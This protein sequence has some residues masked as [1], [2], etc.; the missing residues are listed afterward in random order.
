[1]RPREGYFVRVYRGGYVAL[2]VEL[3]QELGKP[4]YLGW[5]VQ[6]NKL[7]LWLACP[8]SENRV[9]VGHGK[10]NN[11]IRQFHSRR[12]THIK[13]GRY[14]AESTGDWATIPIK[15]EMEGKQNGY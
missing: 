4:A 6:G 7:L 12:L 15:K 1:M 2:S 5:Q 9:K 8:D 11:H 10:H 13:P 14:Y 3:Y